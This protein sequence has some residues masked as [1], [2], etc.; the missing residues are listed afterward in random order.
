MQAA[1]EDALATFVRHPA[2]LVVAGRTDTGV[3]AWGQV[4]SCEVPDACDLE[5]ARHAVNAM[6]PVSIA[7]RALEAVPVGFSAR[8]SARSRT[9]LYRLSGASQPDPFRHRYEWWVRSPVDAD[10]MRAA[11]RGLVGEH[12]FAAFCKAGAAGG[13]VR[14][15]LDVHVDVEAEDRV[16]VWITASS[17][18][19]QMVRSIVGLLEAVGHAR[20]A[21]DDLTQVLA[22]RDRHSN[23][24][25]APPHGLT[26]W[27][28]SYA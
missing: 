14:R 21:P 26:L 9:Y 28:V 17:F 20:R 27:S 19:H 8:F 7:L 22:S 10:R 13:T 16:A 5:R 12:D 15:V 23:S 25:V 11:A 4:F 6:T 24:N 18:C 2:Q 1:V 3:H